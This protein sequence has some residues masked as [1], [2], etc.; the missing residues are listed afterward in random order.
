MFKTIKKMDR[1]DKLTFAAIIYLI[2]NQ[3]Y[4]K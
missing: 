2:E 4:K 1:C 3:Q